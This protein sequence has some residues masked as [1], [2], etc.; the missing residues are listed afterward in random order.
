MKAIGGG[1]RDALE[2]LDTFQAATFR[3]AVGVI[4][5]IV[6]ERRDCKCA[7][8]VVRSATRKPTML[9]GMR[10]FVARWEQASTVG[11]HSTE[12]EPLQTSSP[13]RVLLEDVLWQLI[14]CEMC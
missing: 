8:K 12:M 14:Q 5:Y 6:L 7:A 2:P 10:T 11:G 4:G 13:S 3:S 9:D 1:D